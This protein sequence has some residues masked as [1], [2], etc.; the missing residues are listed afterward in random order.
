LLIFVILTSG[1]YQSD[2]LSSYRKGL[3]LFKIGK[4]NEAADIWTEIGDKIMKS[5]TSLEAFKMAGFAYV[6][7]TV[8]YEKAENAKAYD[9]WAKAIKCYLQGKTTW[10]QQQKKIKEQINKL[11]YELNTTTTEKVNIDE[12]DIFILDIEKEFSISNY[13]GPKPGLK[14]K[15]SKNNEK[16]ITIV[17]DYYARPKKLIE[18]E[19]T[20]QDVYKGPLKGIVPSTKTE[21]KDIAGSFIL[22]RGII[23]SLKSEEE[24]KIEEKK[25]IDKK[26]KEKKEK[27][28]LQN[29]SDKED[30]KITPVPQ[31]EEKQQQ[32]ET[33]EKSQSIL[34]KGE[35]FLLSHKFTEE[36]M[37]IARI[38]WRYF[39]F[40]YQTNTG[41]FNS[42]HK[43]TFTT[44]W[45]MGSSIAALVSAEQ[46]EIIN[47]E[48]FRKYIRLLLQT[49][50][51]IPL[52]NGELPNREYNTKTAKMVD[53]KNRP[54]NKGSGWSALD[55][56]RLLIWLKLVAQWYPEFKKDVQKVVNRWKFDRLILNKE[57][58][59]MFYNGKIEILRQ[60]GRFGYEQYAASGFLLWGITLSNAFDLDETE[61]VKIFGVSI[62][63]DTRNNAF[64]TSEPFILSKIELGGINKEFND[65]IQ[66][67]Y[68][69]QKR[70]W[71]KFEI[72]TAVSEDTL[73]RKPWFIYNNIYLYGKAWVCVSHN[74]RP[75]PQYKNISTKAAIAWS[76]IFIDDYSNKLKLSVKKLFHPKYGFYGGKFEDGGINK[77]LNINTN[78]VILETM[79]YI[80][81]GRKP[82]INLAVDELLKTDKPREL[83]HPKGKS[84]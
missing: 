20:S 40:N 63:H 71:K 78:A 52:Y 7:A 9:T 80:K 72:L 75:Y 49:L 43:Y 1:F 34:P 27:P 8:A 57:M 12:K 58:N 56:G 82:F 64:L 30:T 51:L 69:V 46:L 21:D 25:I 3:S 18:D 66:R 10:K 11:I 23:P 61:E 39:I 6:L 55:I 31:E 68:E 41:M 2:K 76:A 45:D 19:Q 32:I 70:R 77:S 53:L 36:D 47:Q 24:K 67:I 4:F 26:L 74:G 16:K 84:F 79:L 48:Q 14:S 28:K 44:A 50:Q 22:R 38:A 37:Q 83:L 35:A 65:I 17:R 81:R 59:G 29:S 15:I 54:S 5:S 33:G 62:P 60:E 73:D 42:V 13:N